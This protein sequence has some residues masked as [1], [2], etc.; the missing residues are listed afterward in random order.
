MHTP[1]IPNWL[2]SHLVSNS[3]HAAPAKEIVRKW[4][5]Y[6]NNPKMAPLTFCCQFVA[7]GKERG[8]EMGRRW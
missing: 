8:K 3:A 1:T 7:D 4:Y 5:A 6:P 2:P